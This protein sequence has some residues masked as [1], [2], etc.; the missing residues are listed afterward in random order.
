M[1]GAL[2]PLLPLPRSPHCVPAVLG[3]STGL[4]GQVGLS[5]VAVAWAVALRAAWCFQPLLVS[6]RSSK[7]CEVDII[8]CG[9]NC[10]YPKVLTHEQCRSCEW[11][12]QM[13]PC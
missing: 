3:R 9:Y 2:P 10:V 11:L 12:L 6:L 5:V 1:L 4:L 7:Q 8:E 13:N